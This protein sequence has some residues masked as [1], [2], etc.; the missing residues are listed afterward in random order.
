MNV[1]GLQL[2]YFSSYTF[3]FALGIA[4]WRYDW[5]RQLEW[6]NVRP[7]VITLVVAWPTLPIGIAFAN[8]LYGPGKASFGGGLQLAGHPLCVLGALRSL[9]PHRRVAYYSRAHT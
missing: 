6:K 5:L 2:G 8:K 3:L 1:I 9:G 7:W 4:A